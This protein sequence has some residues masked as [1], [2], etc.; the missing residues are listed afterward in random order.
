MWR[1]L[2]CSCC[3][4]GARPI[5]R[6]CDAGFIRR[7]SACVIRRRHTAAKGPR[8]AERA[9]TQVRRLLDVAR[10]RPTSSARTASRTSDAARRDAPGCKRTRRGA[11]ALA[12]EDRRSSSAS[13]VSG[14]RRPVRGEE[15]P[16][17]DQPRVSMQVDS[18]IPPDPEGAGGG[19]ARADSGSLAVARHDATSSTG[20]PPAGPRARRGGG[21]RRPAPSSRAS[22][23][24]CS[25]PTVRRD[26]DRPRDAA[27][28]SSRVRVT[29]RRITV[30]VPR[31]KF[32]EAVV[33]IEALGDVVHRDIVA[34][35]PA[36]EASISASVSATRPPSRAAR[37]ALEARPD[38]RSAGRSSAS[39]R[40]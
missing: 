8:S 10:K 15:A 38:T 18:S 30:R 5:L 37:G 3:S 2:L 6:P 13:P 19:S 14:R 7:E 36:D 23:S 20:L 16:S 39:S 12:G 1:R 35:N 9:R 27:R 11:K 29:I 24:R 17:S 22:T 32:V 28:R 34:E 33:R 25:S 26:G 21:R 40:A 31:P 4:R